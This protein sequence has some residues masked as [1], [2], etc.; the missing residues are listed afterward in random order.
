[1]DTEGNKPKR[2]RR[3]KADIERSIDKAA[4]DIILRKGFSG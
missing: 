2:Y 1:M 3:T 4:K